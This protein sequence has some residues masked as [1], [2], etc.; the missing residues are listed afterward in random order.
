MSP[1]TWDLGPETF[2]VNRIEFSLTMFAFN[3]VQRHATTGKQLLNAR[4]PLL[5]IAPRH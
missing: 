4:G 2:L 1:E 3:F 5:A